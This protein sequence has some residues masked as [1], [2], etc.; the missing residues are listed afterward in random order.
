MKIQPNYQSLLHIVFLVIQNAHN[1]LLEVIRGVFISTK[2]VG[3]CWR[4]KDNL[5]SPSI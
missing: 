2:G 1:H 4:M 3:E 5:I